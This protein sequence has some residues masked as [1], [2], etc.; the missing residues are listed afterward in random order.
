MSRQHEIVGFSKTAIMIVFK[1][2]YFTEAISLNE[3]A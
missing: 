1:F 2:L 3:T